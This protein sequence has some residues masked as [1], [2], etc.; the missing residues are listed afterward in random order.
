MDNPQVQ[1]KVIP[2]LQHKDVIS[3]EIGDYHSVALTAHGDLLA[4]GKFSNGALGLGDPSKIPLGAPG[5]YVEGGNRRGP[6]PDVNIPSKVRFDHGSKTPRNRFCISATAAGW[7]TGALVI[8]LEVLL[9]F[10]SE[11]VVSVY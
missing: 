8:N 6:A 2:E 5:G 1:P 11:R 3:V 4:W 7:H 10:A 9:I